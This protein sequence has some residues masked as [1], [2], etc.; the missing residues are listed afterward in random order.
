MPQEQKILYGKET[1]PG[2]YS[3]L[4]VSTWKN[5]SRGFS[6]QDLSSSNI[7]EKQVTQAGEC[8]FIGR[9]KDVGIGK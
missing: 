9:A 3:Y 2:D 7:L 5:D 1:L 6:T 8:A 4:R